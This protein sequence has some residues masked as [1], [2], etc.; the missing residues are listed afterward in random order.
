MKV[1][2]VCLI[3][4]V[5]VLGIITVLLL[6]YNLSTRSRSG[7]EQPLISNQASTLSR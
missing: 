1:A 4:A 5:V 6:I 3:I 7:Y 2:L